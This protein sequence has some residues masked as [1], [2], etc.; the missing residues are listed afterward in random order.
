MD[1]LST[2]LQS[3][4]SANLDSVLLLSSDRCLQLMFSAHLRKTM[5]CWRCSR[6]NDQFVIPSKGLALAQD[7][8]YLYCK[9]KKIS[10]KNLELFLWPVHLFRCWRNFVFISV[11]SAYLN[12]LVTVLSWC[13]LHSFWY[14]HSC[15]QW[16][17]FWMV[18]FCWLSWLMTFL[19]LYVRRTWSF[20]CHKR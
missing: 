12:I 13:S 5:F 10:K 9:T 18:T 20:Q 1:K 14:C 4:D 19:L 16:Q 7:P 17:K 3:T 2:H 8:Y 6:L 11:A 15:K